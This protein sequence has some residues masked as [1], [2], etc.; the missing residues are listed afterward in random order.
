MIRNSIIQ[1]SGPLLVGLKH[2]LQ[3]L[4]VDSGV[5]ILTPQRYVEALDDMLSGYRINLRGLCI[6]F[7]RPISDAMVVVKN[8][9]YYSLCE[10]HL[11]PFYGSVSVGY[12]PTD[13]V[14]GLSK[15][16]RVVAAFSKRLQLQERMTYE[17]A[18]WIQENLNPAGVMVVAKGVHLCVRMRGVESKSAEMVTSVVMGS[19]RDEASTRAEFLQLVK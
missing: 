8:I 1:N 18:N 15:I 12:I 14:L 6:L 4:Q 13:K 17:I 5:T 19:F 7:E 9:E 10:H 16:P 2:I 11:L 3:D